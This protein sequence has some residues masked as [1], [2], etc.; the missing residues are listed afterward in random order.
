M[1][2]GCLMTADVFGEGPELVMHFLFGGVA[3]RGFGAGVDF[4]E[5]GRVGVVGVSD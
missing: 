5:H 3:W 2:T 4:G 1:P